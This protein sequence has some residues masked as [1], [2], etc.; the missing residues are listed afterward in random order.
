MEL[1]RILKIANHNILSFRFW[2]ERTLNREVV[3][4]ILS[5][6]FQARFF[7]YL[8]ILQLFE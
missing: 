5:R 1:I 8:K 6:Y 7:K 2:N 4:Q 3:Y